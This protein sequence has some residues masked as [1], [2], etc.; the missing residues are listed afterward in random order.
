MRISIAGKI[1]FVLLMIFSFVLLGVTAYQARLEYRLVLSLSK[2]EAHHQMLTVLAKQSTARWMYKAGIPVHAQNTLQS[3]SA[4]MRSQVFYGSA[5]SL[6]SDIGASERQAWQGKAVD[7]LH[8][9]GKATIRILINPFYLNVA[10]DNYQL[11]PWSPDD[12]PVGLVRIDYVLTKALGEIE[13]HVLMTALLLCLFFGA[14]LLF[15]LFIIRRHIVAPLTLISQ[16]ME[17]AADL[18]DFTPRMR[19]ERNDQLGKLSNTFNQL[20]T[21]LEARAQEHSA[22]ERPPHT[23]DH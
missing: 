19:V 12:E 22:V 3:D 8:K 16:A 5:S 9:S 21:T 17:R 15:A 2:A 1:C 10:E 20:M 13:Q 23:S 11:T 18:G 7:T 6:P 4:L 14:G